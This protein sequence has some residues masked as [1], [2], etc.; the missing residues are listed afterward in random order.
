MAPVL[1]RRWRRRLGLRSLRRHRWGGAWFLRSRVS[2]LRACGLF[3]LGI[4]D[5]E[6]RNRSRGWKIV[7]GIERMRG[8]EWLRGGRSN[9]LRPGY[10]SLRHIFRY[11]LALPPCG[12]VTSNVGVECMD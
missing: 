1:A 9:R 10:G 5:P 7:A 12:G 3:G 2:T 6:R 11:S 8:G 4:H